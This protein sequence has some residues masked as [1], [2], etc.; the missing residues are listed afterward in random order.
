MCVCK[1]VCPCVVRLG[2]GGVVMKRKKGELSTPSSTTNRIFWTPSSSMEQEKVKRENLCCSNALSGAVKGFC[3]DHFFFNGS[4]SPFPSPSLTLSCYQS[5]NVHRTH[6]HDKRRE[7]VRGRAICSSVRSSIHSLL[8][9]LCNSPAVRVCV[10]TCV[11]TFSTSSFSLSPSYV[12]VHAYTRTGGRK[13][14][15]R[16]ISL[17]HV[18]SASIVHSLTLCKDQNSYTRIRQT[19]RRTNNCCSRSMFLPINMHINEIEKKKEINR[20]IYNT[21]NQCMR[22][23]NHRL[24]MIISAS[25]Y[26]IYKLNF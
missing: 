9:V 11:Y 1:C 14:V 2:V 20:S 6:T 21:I 18:L 16:S 23:L 19:G 8:S 7:K 13:V 22:K 25:V 24:E 3:V 10:C 5:I 12:Y 17:S 26:Y 15:Q 4:L